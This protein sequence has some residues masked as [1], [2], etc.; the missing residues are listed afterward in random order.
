MADEEESIVIKKIKKGGHGHHGGAWKVAY[1]DFVTAMMAFFLLLWLLSSTS[2][3]QKAG[4]ADY[5]TPTIGL[6]DAMGVGVR[7]GRTATVDGTKNDDKSPPGIVIGAPPKGQVPQAPV[8]E[9]AVVEAEEEQ[10]LFE[11]AKK[12]IKQAM[13]SDPNFREFQDM[14]MFEQSPE[15][16]KITLRDTDTF[17]MFEKGKAVLTSKGEKLLRMI[18][19]VIRKLP[20]RVG[21][22]GHTSLDSTNLVKNPTQYSAWELSA[23]RANA[24]RRFMLVAK[25][26]PN[27][28]GRVVG[29]AD[30]ELL[31]PETPDAPTNRR[32]EILMLKGS[33]VKVPKDFE[34]APRELLNSKGAPEMVEILEENKKANAEKLAPSPAPKTAPAAPAKPEAAQH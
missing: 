15:G 11:D 14:I 4:I 33:H 23:D 32:I 25:M 7:G 1:A 13:E 9:K 30:Q 2:D 26:E 20:N 19:S 8:E 16:L 6:K 5:F 12:E 3:A 27:R 34:T 21:V 17:A 10:R 29:R 28:M 31:T 24:A 22:T 18:T